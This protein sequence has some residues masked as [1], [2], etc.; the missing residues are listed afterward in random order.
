MSIPN[1]PEGEPRSDALDKPFIYYKELTTANK[2]WI[3]IYLLFTIVVAAGYH[4]IDV[5]YAHMMIIAYGLVPQL[6][7]YMILY[8]SL[9]NFRYYLVWLAFSVIHLAM[10]FAMKDDKRLNSIQGN[11]VALLGN[12]I[13]LLLVF[14]LLRWVSLKTQHMEPVAPNKGGNTD[15]FDHRKVTLIDTA[16]FFTYFAAYGFLA[17]FSLG[18]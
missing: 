3:G 17:Y 18:S 14:Q 8:G 13:V 2:W 4:R 5:E 9:R 10:Y 6:F 11:P 1:F 7:F 16:L 15:D 12:T